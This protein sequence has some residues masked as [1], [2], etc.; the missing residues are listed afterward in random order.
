MDMKVYG[1]AIETHECYGHGDYGTEQRICRLGPYGLG[2]F[3]PVFE[4]RE[5]AEEFARKMASKVTL[6]VVELDYLK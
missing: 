5:Q 6:V 2:T 1:L 3:P 4:K